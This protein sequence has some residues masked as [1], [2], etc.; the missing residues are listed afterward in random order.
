LHLKIRT[1]SPFHVHLGERC[2]ISIVTSS[3]GVETL[4]LC[5]TRDAGPASRV[6]VV[7]RCEDCMVADIAP[8]AQPCATLPACYFRE[9]KRPWDRCAL[10]ATFSCSPS[11]GGDRTSLCGLGVSFGRVILGRHCR[12]SAELLTAGQR[13]VPDDHRDDMR[14]PITRRR[15]FQEYDQRT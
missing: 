1:R 2:Q 11:A 4:V 8:C 10:L 15:T 6:M 5:V 3:K 7:T 12:A 14:P 13:A 9:A